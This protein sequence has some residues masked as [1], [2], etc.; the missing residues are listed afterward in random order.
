M[1]YRSWTSYCE[2]IESPSEMVG[3]ESFRQYLY[4]FELLLWFAICAAANG[5]GFVRTYKIEGAPLN[6]W[7]NS[8]KLTNSSTSAEV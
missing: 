3:F 2:S 4:Y 6:T 5:Y 7:L 1:L 8:N